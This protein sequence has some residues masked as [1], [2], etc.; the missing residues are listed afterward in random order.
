MRIATLP[1]MLVLV[2]LGVAITPSRAHA[3]S[4]PPEQSAA[5]AA[6]AVDPDEVKDLIPSIRLALIAR[7][8]DEELLTPYRLRREAERQVRNLPR[9]KGVAP[10]FGPRYSAFARTFSGNLLLR[11]SLAD[12][13]ALDKP[14]TFSFSTF[15]PNDAS[16]GE[17]ARIQVAANAAL[18]LKVHRWSLGKDQRLTLTPIFGAEADLTTGLKKDADRLTLRAG[19]TI[20]LQ[21]D[22]EGWA[23]TLVIAYD[24][25]TDRDFK[26][27]VRGL[28]IQYSLTEVK[29]SL[30]DSTSQD[31]VSFKWRPTAGY[32]WQTVKNAADIPALAQLKDADV[33]FAQS[34]LEVTISRLVIKPTAQL[35][36]RRGS[37][38]ANF[39]LGQWTTSIRLSPANTLVKVGLDLELS[40]GH[41]YPKFVR[42]QKAKL[43]LSVQF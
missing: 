10:A 23:D 41:R 5:R 40:A 19:G 38:K 14:A 15:H 22:D 33:W 25:S 32:T 39:A 17:N 34:E 37:A 6:Q 3:Q 8:V 2:S 43:A 30:W 20:T 4:T 42:E 1:V 13:A 28:S 12:L 18:I 9:V 35:G 29:E 26:A 7:G 11:R 36:Q 16:V 24:R 21:P 27:D 31:T